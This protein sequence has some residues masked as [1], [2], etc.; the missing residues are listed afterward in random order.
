MAKPTGVEY[1]SLIPLTDEQKR[2]IPFILHRNP[3]QTKNR[4]TW[5]ET[6]EE[7][8]AAGRVLGGVFAL[9][10]ILFVITGA[11]TLSFAPRDDKGSQGL[12]ERIAESQTDGDVRCLR[13]ARRADF[14]IA[15]ASLGAPAQHLKLLLRLDRVLPRDS[16]GSNLRIFSERLHKSLTMHC[17]PFATQQPVPQERCQDVALLFNGTSRQGYVHT[18]FTYANDYVEMGQHNR[19]AMLGLDG[20][21]YLEAGRTYWLTTTH[22]CFADAPETLA[23][24]GSDALGLGVGA[25]QLLYAFPNE[26]L[27]FQPTA[28]T[29]VATSLEA[30]PN[31][32]NAP[33]PV[34]IFPSD[35]A[36]E[37]ITWLSLSDTFLYEYGNSVL[38][39]RRTVVE[40][41]QACAKTQ[42]DLKHI[43][44]LYRLDCAII[45]PAW[46]QVEPALP[47]RRL[48]D[49]RLRIDISRDG[50]EGVLRAEQS[51][52]LGR[53]PGLL[54]YDDGLGAAFARLLIML[55][56]AAVVF[57]R[58]SQNASSS[59]YML[60]HVLDTIR[61]RARHSKHPTDYRWALFHNVSEIAVDA[62]ITIV[63]LGSRVLVLVLSGA[64]LVADQ[65]AFVVVFES[66]G[67]VASAA[68]FALRYG[69]LKWD[70][71]REAPL[72]KLAGPMSI[73][74]VSS[75]VLLAF[76]EPPLL[77][78]DEGRF[79]AVGRLLIGIM[80][81]ISVVTR[82][83]FAAP[84]CGI[85]ANTVVNDEVTY[86]DLK[87]YWT[88]LVAGC[89][90][91]IVQGIV[92]CVTL[93]A[94]FVGPAAYAVVRMQTG[95]VVEVI[96]YCLFAGLL[97]AGLPTVTKVALRT[98]EHECDEAEKQS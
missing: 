65:L 40:V 82:C 38:E 74:D 92:S 23:F 3:R 34:R 18:R 63:A 13:I 52:A 96:P 88:V 28:S 72:T 94:L 86:R 85:L 49:H 39:R 89:F 95:A 62:A 45:D 16:V 22:F 21:L 42:P 68:H 19:A 24:T 36:N 87:G 71:A 50:T 81:A 58:G 60:E 48:A 97:C 98:L 12:A 25:D 83:A 26:L 51:D 55:L 8:I 31:L 1:Q 75:A 41:G 43:D 11:L 59:R 56:T 76:S 73:C 17:D 5:L 32:V 47:F 15:F 90:L 14:A 79:P 2:R 84:M 54:S 78:N 46:C 35:A 10:M 6:D 64:T 37:R 20:E 67:I 33:T 70:L 44:D 57:V 80:I 91:W 93:T 4:K 69:V 7:R 9:C 61:C 30:C 53:I 77:S 29:P 27:A 66:I